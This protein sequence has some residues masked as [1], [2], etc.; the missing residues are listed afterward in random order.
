MKVIKTK[1]KTRNRIIGIF[2]AATMTLTSM[3]MG[4]LVMPF[5]SAY[6]AIRALASSS[7]E[8]VSIDSMQKL[9]EY[10]QNYDETHVHDIIELTFGDN[11]TVGEVVG[12]IPIAATEDIA[13]EG[14]IK[15]GEGMQLNLPTSMFG[16]VTDDVEIVKVNKESDVAALAFTRTTG[17][18]DQPLFAQHVKNNRSSGSANWSF[19]YDEFRAD[20]TTANRDVFDYAGFIG[21]LGENASVKISKITNNNQG[22]LNN[23][24]TYANISATGDAGLVCCTMDTGSHLEIDEISCESGNF[25]VSGATAGGLVGS[26]AAG[27]T[28]ILGDGLSSVQDGDM[29]ITATN[30]YAG[31]LVGSCAG[32][33]TFN[34]SGDNYSVNQVISGSSGS[35]GV[36]GYY[37]TNATSNNYAVNYSKF[38]LGGTCRLNGAGNCGGLFGEVLNDGEMTI[39][40]SVGLTANHGAGTAASFGGLVGKYTADSLTNSLTVSTSE[41]TSPNKSADDASYYGGIIGVV[42]GSS[43]VKFDAVQVNSSHANAVNYFGGLVG[44]SATGFIELSGENKI[45]YGGANTNRNYGGVVGNLENGV[46]IL[47]GTTDLTGAANVLAGTA[48]TGQIVGNRSCGFIWAEDGWILKNACWFSGCIFFRKSDH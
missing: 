20:D 37:A 13:F 46:L 40:D 23:R 26:M 47:S 35:G 9:A 16:W 6:H 10:A 25:T 17:T 30:G 39:T 24:E 38:S 19:Q 4:E 48:S 21:T 2:C 42:D 41:A 12:F 18:A 31:G 27:S 32:M 22:I 11:S 45:S 5:N 28:L 34:H 7:G 44:A 15:V 29:T 14:K 33:I 43:Y 8:A 3:P 1:N 36:A